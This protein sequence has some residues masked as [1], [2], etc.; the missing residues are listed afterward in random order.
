MYTFTKLPP[1]QKDGRYNRPIDVLRAMTWYQFVQCSIGYVSNYELNKIFEG[2]QSKWSLYKKGSQ[3]TERLLELVESKVPGSRAVY[4]AGPKASKLWVALVSENEAELNLIVKLGRTIDQTIAQFRLNVL[5]KKIDVDASHGTYESHPYDDEIEYINHVLIQS[6]LF[7]F[8]EPLNDNI[9]TECTREA[10]Q[11][12][13]ESALVTNVIDLLREV[14]QPFRK[15]SM[16]LAYAELI[17]AVSDQYY[18]L[19]WHKKLDDEIAFEDLK[20]GT[21]KN[22]GV[23]LRASVPPAAP[24]P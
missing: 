1:N 9:S 2:I 7:Y 11:K 6:E 19:A 16:R 17:D 8:I 12:S 22:K 21:V 15:E 4:E 14:V 13:G 20:M 5:N 18:D 23:K 3:P 24:A 10:D